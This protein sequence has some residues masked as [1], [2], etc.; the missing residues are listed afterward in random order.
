MFTL[1]LGAL[2]GGATVLLWQQWT[3]QALVPTSANSG[4]RKRLRQRAHQATVRSFGDANW[5]PARA[6]RYTTRPRS[7]AA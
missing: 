5:Q 2:I 3:Q 6:S 7:H 1:V 4:P